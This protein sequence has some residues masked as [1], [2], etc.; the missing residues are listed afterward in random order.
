ML[1][2][3]L[4]PGLATR[5]SPERLGSRRLPIASLTVGWKPVGVRDCSSS[6]VDAAL[7]CL[8]H[9]SPLVHLTEERVSDDVMGLIVNPVISV[10]SR[11]HQMR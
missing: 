2:R 8:R 10:D 9:F 4:S 6:T 1:V 7:S 11:D 5:H 3:D